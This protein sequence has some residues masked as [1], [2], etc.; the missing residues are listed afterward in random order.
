MG[1]VA[2]TAGE[3]SARGT[4]WSSVL[5]SRWDR[6]AL[7]VVAT[8]ARWSRPLIVWVP[9]RLSRDRS[10]RPVTGRGSLRFRTS[11][12]HPGL[13]LASR[14]PVRD[15]TP[16]PR[17]GDPSAGRWGFGLEGG[18]SRA[19]GGAPGWAPGVGL[20]VESLGV[21]RCG[22]R[23]ARG[24]AGSP[25][26]HYHTYRWAPGKAPQESESHLPGEYTP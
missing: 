14:A 11:Y 25:A 22:D 1:V 10:P 13:S 16:P 23:D 17:G 8:T 6:S 20:P 19:R 3:G 26:T 12:G 18:G 2:T 5:G 4:L 15:G 21:A 9:C 7:S 24:V